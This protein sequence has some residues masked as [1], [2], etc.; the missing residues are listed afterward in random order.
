MNN[1]IIEENKIYLKE[2]DKVLAEIEFEKIDNNTYNIYH[3]YVDEKLRGQGI[4]SSLVEKAVKYIE[5]KN[6]K[7]TA[8][9]SYA[10]KWLEKNYRK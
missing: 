2:N 3:T 6:K 1:F 10:Q 8:S 9:C 5:S 4:A 7:V